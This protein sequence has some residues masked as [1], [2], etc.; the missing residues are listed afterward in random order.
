MCGGPRCTIHVPMHVNAYDLWCFVRVV[1]LNL[2]IFQVNWSFQSAEAKW[3]GYRGSRRVPAPSKPVQIFKGK[4]GGQNTLLWIPTHPLKPQKV[5]VG[6]KYGIKH[7]NY[8]ADPR[9]HNIYKNV[10]YSLSHIADTVEQHIFACMKFS[11]DS[12]KSHAQEYYLQSKNSRKFHAHE[13]PDP[14]ICKSHVVK[15]SCATILHSS[16][17]G[18][19][20]S[21]L[22]NLFSLQWKWLSF[23]GIESCLW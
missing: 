12:R 16:W 18:C 19:S 9:C 11:R 22:V 14:Q 23:V 8:R 5:R 3:R 20:M 2:Y 10:T 15:F 1:P 6:C 7:T 21:T 17:H 13:L 4:T